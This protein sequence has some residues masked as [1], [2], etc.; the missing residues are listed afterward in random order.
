MLSPKFKCTTPFPPS[1]RNHMNERLLEPKIVWRDAAKLFLQTWQC[2]KQH[3]A[4]VNACTRSAQNQ[5]S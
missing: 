4:T 3:T 5:A 1:L 2:T